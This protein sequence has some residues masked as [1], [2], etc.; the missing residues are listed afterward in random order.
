MATQKQVTYHSQFTQELFNLVEASQEIA[1]MRMQGVRESVLVTR[2][3][4]EGLIDIFKDVRRSHQDEIAQLIEVGKYHATEQKKEA[5]SILLSPSG[6]FSGQLAAAVFT[7]FEAYLQQKKTDVVL[8]GD[9]GRSFLERQFGKRLTYKYFAINVEQP[10]RE[11]ITELLKYVSQYENVTVFTGK[12]NSLVTQLPTA[13]NITG[14]ESLRTQTQTSEKPHPFLYEPALGKIVMFFSTQVMAALF[15]QTLQESKLAN[16]GS[17]IMAL[18][19]S[20]TGITNE[21]HQLRKLS[22]RMNRRTQNRKQTNRLSGIR[23]WG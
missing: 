1:V 17:R 20:R 9:T 4:M 21:L 6:K 5:V 12:F 16:L 18:E 8:V 14:Y 10:S 13:F 11:Q 15:R 7:Q 2:R 19:A 23:L 3:Y 22:Y